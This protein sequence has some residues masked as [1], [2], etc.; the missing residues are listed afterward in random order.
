[1]STQQFLIRLPEE[2]AARLKAVVPARQRNKF[3]TELVATAVAHHEAKLAKIAD[4]VT[5]EEKRNPTIAQET[6]DW[7]AT[8]GDGLEEKHGA[9]AKPKTR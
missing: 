1:M 8:V 9:H 3:V 5:N 7:E 4:A 2:V 6:R